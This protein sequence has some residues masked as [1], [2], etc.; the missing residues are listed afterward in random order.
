[1]T[2]DRQPSYMKW[3]PPSTTATITRCEL[4][5][6]TMKSGFIS[7]RHRSP[8]KG[9]SVEFAEHRQYMPG[10]DL[11]TLDWKVFGRKDRL[12]VR[13]YEEETN[14]RATVLLDASGSMAYAGDAAAEMDGR[15]L[16]KFDY[17]RYLAAG[18]SYMLA[19]QQDAVGLVTFDT[20]MR[21]YLPAKSSASQTRRILET[22]DR[23]A[24]GGETD[25]APVFD[26]IAERIPARG[27]VVILSDLFT[28]DQD[29]LLKA[30]HHFNYRRHEIVVMHV[31]A[32]EELTFGFDGHVHF[33]NLEGADE[34][35]LDAKSIRAGYLEQVNAFLRKIGDGVRRMNADYVPVNTKVPF[36]RVLVDFLSRRRAGG[37]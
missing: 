16:S 22:L 20:K 3:L 35:A 18:M 34:M 12:Y 2:A 7:G 32:E 31:M 33:D 17:A 4:F 9:N 29:A 24:P 14:L 6:R 19:G 10:D 5:G 30:L 15:P 36:D 13:Q 21:E 28:S 37:R 1:M 25:P 11:R 23:S 8:K 26:D 27:L